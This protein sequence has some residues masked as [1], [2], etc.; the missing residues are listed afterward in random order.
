[1]SVTTKETARRPSQK[2]SIFSK[3]AVRNSESHFHKASLKRG[4]DKNFPLSVNFFH[5]TST[6][7]VRLHKEW[8]KQNAIFKVF[9]CRLL[10]LRSE[11]LESNGCSVL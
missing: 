10:D 4:A 7:D 1:M 6:S 2:A 8:Y 5:A 11:L 3:T 9:H